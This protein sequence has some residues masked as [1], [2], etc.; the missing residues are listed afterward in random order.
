LII[1]LFKR[2]LNDHERILIE[3]G[4][5]CYIFIFINLGSI[6]QIPGWRSS[7]AWQNRG[8][9]TSRSACWLLFT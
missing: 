4:S 5:S 3:V 6:W 2:A 7:M 9:W 8:I 1:S